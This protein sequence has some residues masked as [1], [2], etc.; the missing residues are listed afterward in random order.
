MKKSKKSE[1]KKPVTKPK[2]FGVV[3]N[4]VLFYYDQFDYDAISGLLMFK[5]ISKKAN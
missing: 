5:E 2:F 4:D 1:Q 3:V